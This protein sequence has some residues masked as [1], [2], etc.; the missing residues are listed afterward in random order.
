[1]TTTNTQERNVAATTC[2]TE[3]IVMLRSMSAED[4]FR[5]AVNELSSLG[6]QVTESDDDQNRVEGVIESSQVHRLSQVETVTY[7]RKLHSYVA[8]FLDRPAQAQQFQASLN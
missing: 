6:L 5:S 7:V 3:V 4:E 8:R 2:M 1:M